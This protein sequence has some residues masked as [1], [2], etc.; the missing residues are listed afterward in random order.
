MQETFYRPLTQ[1]IY[2][3]QHKCSPRKKK[4]ATQSPL[5]KHYPKLPN[6][7]PPPLWK[8]ISWFSRGGGGAIIRNHVF[9][10]N[11]TILFLEKIFFLVFTRGGGQLLRG[12]QLLGNFGYIPWSK[13]YFFR[14]LLRDS[15]RIKFLH[16]G[17]K[18]NRFPPSKK[19]PTVCV[20]RGALKIGKCFSIEI[21]S[22]GFVHPTFCSFFVFLKTCSL[23][24]VRM[25]LR[26]KFC[27]IEWS[28]LNLTNHVMPM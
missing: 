4:Y 17:W 9:V 24:I 23:G 5:K 27:S 7:C 16:K 2:H 21:V 11:K 14:K 20:G 6:N 12:G 10:K 28:R 26:F 18:G 1:W 15:K 3:A 25:Y 22:L 19:S 8:K 13:I